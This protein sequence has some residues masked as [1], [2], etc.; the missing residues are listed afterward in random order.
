M[1]IQNAV[2]HDVQFGVRYE[3]NL[4]NLRIWNG[5]FG[6]G[7]QNAFWPAGVFTPLAAMDIRNVLFMGAIPVQAP[8]PSTALLRRQ[9]S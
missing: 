5:T 8:S 7:V 2:V 3:D 4:Q 6:A 9:T 1:R